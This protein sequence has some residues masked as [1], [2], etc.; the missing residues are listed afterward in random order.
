MVDLLLI[1]ETGVAEQTPSQLPSILFA[2]GCGLLAMIL[3]RRSYRYFGKRTRG[4]SG[5][6]IAA[7]PRP[8]G[9]W[10]GAKRDAAARLD[11]ER[12]E[13]HELARDLMGQLDSKTRVLNQ[14]VAQSQQQIER[15]EVLLDIAAREEPQMDTDEHA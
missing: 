10:D 8:T 12:V 7:Q 9:P 2:A 14:L 4:G 11:R 6:A 3:L 1:A 13:L 15:L 5:P